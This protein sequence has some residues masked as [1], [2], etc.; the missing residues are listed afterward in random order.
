MPSL[1][2]DFL[3]TREGC[4]DLRKAW[5]KSPEG[6]TRN[7]VSPPAVEAEAWALRT[8]ACTAPFASTLQQTPW[9]LPSLS[10]GTHGGWVCKCA[11]TRLL[12]PSQVFLNFLW[13]CLTNDS[14][15]PYWLGWL[16]IDS[17][18]NRGLQRACHRLPSRTTPDQDFRDSATQHQK[19]SQ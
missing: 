2:F 19:T 3:A 12:A 11:L 9:T 16:R 14:H 4:S 18:E 13:V 8:P 17:N 15:F 5:M 1:L 6:I 10:S 7:L